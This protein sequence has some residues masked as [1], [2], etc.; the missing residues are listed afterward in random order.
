MT[1]P[2][3]AS[4]PVPRSL[5]PDFVLLK[6]AAKDAGRL[7]FS[8]FRQELAV[9]RKVDGSEVSEADLAVDAALKHALQVPK[10][11]GPGFLPGQLSQRRAHLRPGRAGFAAR[12]NRPANIGRS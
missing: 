10:H 6:Q 9:K 2:K 12:A 5:Q 11:D 4:A 1:A 8:Y 7:A 3:P